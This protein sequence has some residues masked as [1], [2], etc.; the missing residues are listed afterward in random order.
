MT[1]KAGRYLKLLG[2]TI[3]GIAIFHAIVE[4]IGTAADIADPSPEQQAAWNDFAKQYQG[5]LDAAQNN[6]L[7]NEDA[8]RLRQSF[9][10]YVRSM[11]NLGMSDEAVDKLDALIGAKIDLELPTNK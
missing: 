9:I 5:A 2:K 1:G 8:H 4:G 7:S 11:G 3:V 10:R 6:T